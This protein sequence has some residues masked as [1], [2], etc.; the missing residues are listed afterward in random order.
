MAC[1]KSLTTVTF[2]TLGHFK[3]MGC[4]QCTNLC[5]TKLQI[6]DLIKS[7]VICQLLSIQSLFLLLLW[8]RLANRFVLCHSKRM[9]DSVHISN[10]C[11]QMH[12][13][14]HPH[15]IYHPPLKCFVCFSVFLSFHTHTPVGECRLPVFS[16][17]LLICSFGFCFLHC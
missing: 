12:A 14:G 10:V 13:W 6:S 16:V 7:K 8:K 5:P 15:P 1:N 17:L 11:S 9:S 2:M 4:V 3:A